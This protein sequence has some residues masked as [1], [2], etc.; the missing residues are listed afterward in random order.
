MIAPGTARRS[1][2]TI[3]RNPT[4]A[5]NAA[6]AFKSPFHV[7]DFRRIEQQV[8][9]RMEARLQLPCRTVPVRQPP[10]LLAV[11]DQEIEAAV[12]VFGFFSFFYK[13]F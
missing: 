10:E 4:A 12:I 8:A 6:G 2:A 11:G 3:T 13:S 7:Q 5:S 1:S 9:E